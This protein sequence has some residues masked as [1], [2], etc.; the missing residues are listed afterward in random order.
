MLFNQLSMLWNVEILSTVSDHV[1]D[2]Q[3]YLD[4]TN[5]HAKPFGRLNGI[6]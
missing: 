6:L 1:G 2:D 5:E 4:N 3:I